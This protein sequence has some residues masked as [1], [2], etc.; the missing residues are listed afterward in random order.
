MGASRRRAVEAA[1]SEMKS[2]MMKISTLLDNAWGAR[3]AQARMYE[4]VFSR[5][6][7]IFRETPTVLWRG[8]G[9]VMMLGSISASI[10]FLRSGMDIFTLWETV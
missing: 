6:K 2:G 5:S 8:A 9:E 7:Y 4:A 3:G 1:V 10:F